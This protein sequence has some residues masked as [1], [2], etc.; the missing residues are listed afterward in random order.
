ML[1]EMAIK[2]PKGV[3]STRY[4]M[5]KQS[6]ADEGGVCDCDGTMYYG[7]DHKV[8]RKD[9]KGNIMKNL[10]GETIMITEARWHYK[11]T[12]GPTKCSSDIF[13]S[14]FPHAKKSCSCNFKEHGTRCAE[15]RKDCDCTGSMYFGARDQYTKICTKGV[16]KC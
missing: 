7:I 13:G 2:V 16:T 5:G 1:L 11:P 14:F 4:K 6:C 3:K 9:S 8:P 10:K 15:W 12:T